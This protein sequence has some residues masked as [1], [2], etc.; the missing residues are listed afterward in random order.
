MWLRNRDKK[1]QKWKLTISNRLDWQVKIKKFLRRECSRFNWIYFQNFLFILCD[2]HNVYTASHAKYDHFDKTDWFFSGILF[3]QKPAL[4]KIITYL[5]WTG[6][7]G[8]LLL[9]LF[10]VNI[11]FWFAV[12][13][14]W[15]KFQPT[16][17]WL[18]RR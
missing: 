1:T 16:A 14:E 13:T 17:I 7:F 12:W 5:T 8:I 9:I 15:S 4:T 2:T 18:F 10:W 3:W 11:S 6:I